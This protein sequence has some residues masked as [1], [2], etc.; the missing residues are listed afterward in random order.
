M[1]TGLLARPADPTAFA[2]AVVS[3]LKDKEL[4][5]RIGRAAREEVHSRYHWDHLA[6]IAERAYASATASRPSSR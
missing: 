2:A 6:S 4:G 5:Q 3:L 1:R